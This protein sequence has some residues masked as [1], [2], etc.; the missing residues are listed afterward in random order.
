MIQYSLPANTAL[1]LTASRARSPVFWEVYTA[2][3]RQ[4]NA[5]PLG[6]DERLAFPPAKAGM[7]A[8]SRMIEFAI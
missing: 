5:N 2:R 4:L 1:Q 6:A 7:Q 3:S 8:T